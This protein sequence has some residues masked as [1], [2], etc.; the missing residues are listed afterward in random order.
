MIDDPS[1]VQQMLFQAA[2]TVANIA[3]Y[4]RRLQANNKK[5]SGN[6]DGIIARC[7]K[8]TAQIGEAIS[9]SAGSHA[10]EHRGDL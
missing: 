2:E 7:Q 9:Q 6:L 3:A 8:A 4:A 5:T 1:D 10:G